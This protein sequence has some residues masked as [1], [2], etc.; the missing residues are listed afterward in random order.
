MGILQI[1]RVYQILTAVMD[2]FL[3][4]QITIVLEEPVIL[5]TS[6]KIRPHVV[7]LKRRVMIQLIVEKDIDMMTQNLVFTVVELLVIQ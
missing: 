7:L 3:N 2:L 5:I 1:F 6:L 4:N